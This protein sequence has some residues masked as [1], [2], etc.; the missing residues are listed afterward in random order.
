MSVEPGVL[1]ANILV[2]A[3]D[4]DAPQHADA[5]TLVEAARNPLTT[6]YVT[7][8]ILCEFYSV[9]TNPKRVKNPSTPQ[10]AINIVS[11]ILALP[12]L[13]ILP[14]PVHAVSGLLELLKR[15]PVAAGDVFDLQ[16]IATMLANN[17]RRIYTFNARDFAMFSELIVAAP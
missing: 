14:S 8:Q 17:I 13:R 15:H 12:G 5:R 7:S 1:D 6:L 10:D 2:Y 3:I 16:I 4:A 9:I 11:A